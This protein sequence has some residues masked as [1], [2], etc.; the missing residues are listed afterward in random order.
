[1]PTYLY[2]TQGISELQEETA[3][4]SEERLETRLERV[5]SCWIISKGKRKN[6]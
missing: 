2:Y 4:Y 5:G 1:M 3:T 6:A